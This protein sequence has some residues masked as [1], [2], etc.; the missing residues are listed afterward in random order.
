MKTHIKT[1]QTR[2]SSP[3]I[4]VL[5]QNISGCYVVVLLRILS[6]WLKHASTMNVF[7]LSSATIFQVSKCSV[8]SHPLELP[9]VHFLCQH[10]FH[11]QL[12]L[13][14]FPSL[15]IK[16]KILFSFLAALKVTV[17]M[18]LSALYVSRKT[19]IFFSLKFP[20]MYLFLLSF[21]QKSV[22]YSKS[23][24]TKSWPA[25]SVSNSA[26]SRSRRVFRDCRLLW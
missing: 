18:I 23:S 4:L 8:C 6:K 22:W 5:N 24:R 13:V 14:H 11:Q 12:S 2:W 9:S 10:S 1:L 26:W 25:W 21:I 19:G 7:L 15:E 17:R 16:K 3:L 20:N